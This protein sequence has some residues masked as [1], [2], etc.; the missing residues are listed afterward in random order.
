M[1]SVRALARQ[2]R[3]KRVAHAL[4]SRHASDWRRARSSR[5]ERVD[6]YVVRL[7][8]WAWLAALAVGTAT[9]ATR[10]TV[11]SGLLVGLAT[12]VGVRLLLVRVGFARLRFARW[13]RDRRLDHAMPHAAATL[14]RCVAGTTDRE[15]LFGA[16]VR[17]SDG[18]TAQA[19]ASLRDRA[20]LEGAGSALESTARTTRS[21]AF[22]D[23]CRALCGPEETLPA[24]LDALDTTRERGEIEKFAEGVATTL[25][26]RTRPR[27]RRR[28]TAECERF[29]D[30][31]A[32]D[33]R[34]GATLA[35]SVEHAAD[36]EYDAF[37]PE[38]DRLAGGVA[39]DGP[40]ATRHAFEQSADAVDAPPARRHL[41]RVAA[42]LACDCS[43]EVAVG[44]VTDAITPTSV[45]KRQRS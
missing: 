13:R 30:A 24:R 31:V 8:T 12:V 37:A 10:P 2:A 26:T 42:A 40:R 9:A 38:L 27:T 14:R 18:P 45:E 36:G 41:R 28:Q 35:A 16:V 1:D 3:P 34:A 20:T 33:L 6:G 39:V 23:C 25:R 44:G 22:A 15:R 4:F 43:P 19:F 11:R 7:Y 17:T 21:S 32:A 5:T 29:L